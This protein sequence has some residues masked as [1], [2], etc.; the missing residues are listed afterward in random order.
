MDSNQQIFTYEIVID[1]R[2]VIRRKRQYF[3]ESALRQILELRALGSGIATDYA[4][5]IVTSVGLD[6]G[7]GSHKTFTLDYYDTQIP[8]GRVR[9][10]AGKPFKLQVSL[11]GSLSA[12]DF[13]R[14][15][16]PASVN[17]DHSNTADTEAIRA[18]NV[19]IASH[20][21]KDPDVYRIGHNKF[22]KYPPQKVFNN[23]EL[24]GGLIAVRGYFSSARFSTSRILLNLNSQCSPFYKT[25]NAWELVHEFQESSPGDWLAL[26][27]FLFRLRVKTSYTK[28]PNGTPLSRIWSITGFSHKKLQSDGTDEAS[29][30][31]EFNHG[32]AN[33]IR[34]KLKGR[35]PEVT[36]SV[37]EYFLQ[38]Q[39]P[40]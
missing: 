16:D 4:S 19:I 6:L 36:M 23:Y 30:D 29:R 2:L 14:F 21:N 28:A 24:T 3:V 15:T 1:N 34:F 9:A 12:S 17:S 5:L 38:G 8:E 20:P 27:H 10:P 39:L 7:P 22:F 18:L 37:K 25:M 26:H 35:Q 33:E 40:T 11:T 13:L 32:N 31:S